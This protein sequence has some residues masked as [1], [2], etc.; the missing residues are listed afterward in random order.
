[1]PAGSTLPAAGRTLPPLRLVSTRGGR[2]GVAV[3]VV[4][5]FAIP[6]NMT[7]IVGS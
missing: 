5:V 7:N 6:L 1:M 3:F 4:L 2:I